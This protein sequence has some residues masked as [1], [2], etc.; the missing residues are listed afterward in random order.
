M[1]ANAQSQTSIRAFRIG[2]PL[3]G[4]ERTHMQTYAHVWVFLHLLDI[5]KNPEAESRIDKKMISLAYSSNS[6]R[7]R[8][9][10]Q[11]TLKPFW[12]MRTYWCRTPS[13]FQFL[14]FLLEVHAVVFPG[15]T[16]P[17]LQFWSAD[18][19]LKSHFN[20]ISQANKGPS[21]K[22]AHL[23]HAR[24]ATALWLRVAHIE[25]LFQTSIIRSD[26]QRSRP[27]LLFVCGC[28]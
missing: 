17:L 20:E 10:N 18:T 15:L 28:R 8:T 5:H 11:L 27:S 3:N 2:P 12:R 4:A 23:T 9:N 16:A 14:W 13:C 1:E 21:T 26:Q 7:G 24:G 22:V 19:D 25:G 6:W